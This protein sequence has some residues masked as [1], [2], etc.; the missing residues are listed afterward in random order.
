MKGAV[1]ADL[2]D[3]I[4]Q[5][6]CLSLLKRLVDSSTDLIVS[7]P[8]YNIGKAYEQ[9]QSLDRYLEDQAVILTEC[10]RILKPTGSI[11]WQIG[12]YVDDGRHIPLDVKVFPILESLGM[13]PRNRIVWA[14]THGLHG[15]N[16]FSCR[17]ET[18]LWFTKGDDYKFFLDPIRVPQKYPEKTSWRAHNKGELTSHP[19]GKNPGDVWAFRNV[20]HNH[21]EQT[22][23]PCQ[24]PEDM[25]ERIVLA[26]T[27]PDDVVLDPY[28]G[29]GTVAVVARD[30]GRHYVGAEIDRKYHEVALHR[31]SGEPDAKGNFPN[32]KTLRQYA[33]RRGTE[34]LGRFSFTM[35]SGKI[36]T[37][38]DRSRIYPESAHLESLEEALEVESEQSAYAR[39]LVD[40]DG[41][42]K[43]AG[44]RKR[45]K[46][47]PLLG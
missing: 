2:L 11:F 32:L 29:A 22:I 27:E 3:S 21:E 5:G 4:Y 47:L 17:H 7:S 41:R 42:I 40:K 18:L 23:H 19:L 16:R 6:D 8:P 13:I 25:I 31:L 46:Q 39:G 33:E 38:T 9:R 35:Q 28:M 12:A 1:P 36:A 24:F 15:R 44:D 10:H 34:D 30:L 20:K 37:T 43:N 45:T 26:T 14:R